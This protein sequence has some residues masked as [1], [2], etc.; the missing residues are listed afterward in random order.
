MAII[1]AL[2]SL[3]F[4]AAMYASLAKLAA[5]LY[6][7]TKLSWKSAFGFGALVALLAVIATVLRG[8]LPVFVV[9]T[10]GHALVLA[11]GAW[12]LASRAADASGQ[13]VGFKVAVVLSCIA[14]GMAFVVGVVLAVVLPAIMRPAL[15]R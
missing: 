5:R 9:L 4:L 14:M 11:V 2:L 12:F 1:P 3:L 10:A 6:R 8:V 13:P 7:S 15:H